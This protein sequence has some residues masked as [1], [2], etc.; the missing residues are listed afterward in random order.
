MATWKGG[1]LQSSL[2]ELPASAIFAVRCVD[3]FGFGATR[4]VAWLTGALAIE[5]AL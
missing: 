5:A 2:R 3:G 1:L 4:L